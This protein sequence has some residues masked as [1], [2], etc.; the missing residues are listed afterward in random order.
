VIADIR[1]LTAASPFVPFTVHLVDGGALRVPTIHHI[2]V[3]P[4]PERVFIWGDHGRYD[5][6]RPT[7]IT[8]VTVEDQ[9]NGA[10]SIA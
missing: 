8:R 6:I 1:E 9:P 4:A 10:T 3:T 5:K 7:M 2:H